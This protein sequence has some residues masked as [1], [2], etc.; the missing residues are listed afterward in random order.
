M[1][2]MLDV[3]RIR[4]RPRIAQAHQL[5]VD[6][7]IANPHVA[8]QPAVRVGRGDVLLQ[9][10]GPPAH[11]GDVLR[12]GRGAV[13]SAHLRRV[14]ADVAERELRARHEHFDGVAVDDFDDLRLGEPGVGRR[15]RDGWRGR[16][17]RCRLGRRSRR[18]GR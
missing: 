13:R 1:R 5:R 11:Q 16:L 4:H 12:A 7:Q 9:A 14:D 6:Q 17:C 8:Q 18:G 2:L 3:R 15:G 10:H